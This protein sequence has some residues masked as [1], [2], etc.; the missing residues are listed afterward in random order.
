MSL[1]D[2]IFGRPAPVSKPA[3][4]AVPPQDP[5]ATRRELL[6]VVFRDTLRLHGLPAA[7]I[8]AELLGCASRDGK[9]GIHMRLQLR[10]WEPRLLAHAPALQDSLTAR[11]K[12]FDPLAIHWFMG[13][14]WQFSLADTSGCPPMPATSFW[15]A[16]VAPAPAVQE[17]EDMLAEPSPLLQSS[18]PAAARRRAEL[19]LLLAEGDRRRGSQHRDGQ[20]GF[21][22]T[23]PAFQA[24][25]P[26]GL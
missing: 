13:I 6:R 23:Q 26:A 14:S 12:L 19:E 21:E 18:Q 24:T 20:P 16:P 1:M 15:T 3:V 17:V 25:E 2:R 8:T 9:Q 22:A 4:S 10:H 11:V 5:A 7:W